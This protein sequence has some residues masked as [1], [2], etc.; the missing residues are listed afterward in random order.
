MPLEIPTRAFAVSVHLGGGADGSSVVGFA[1]GRATEVMSNCDGLQVVL[2]YTKSKKTIRNGP[3]IGIQVD[4]Y[5]E[6]RHHAAFSA[7]HN[8][9]RSTPQS[10]VTTWRTGYQSLNE[11]ANTLRLREKKLREAA[12]ALVTPVGDSKSKTAWTKGGRGALIEL[13]QSIREE[14]Q[15]E[16]DSTNHPGLQTA[17]ESDWDQTP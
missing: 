9:W 8:S 17:S 5:P 15:I 7:L 1:N 2:G 11:R 13:A 6:M 3:G 4:N 12:Q 16:M 10:L 14:L